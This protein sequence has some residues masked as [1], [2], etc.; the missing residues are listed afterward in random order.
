M[1]V[2]EEHLNF[3]RMGVARGWWEDVDEAACLPVRVWKMHDFHETALMAHAW[4]RLGIFDSV[5]AAKREGH[6][7]PLK[8]GT[9][10]KGTR[11]MRIEA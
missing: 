2:S 8:P 4:V 11:I 7:V 5:K 6:A 9:Y 10:R 3:L 1:A